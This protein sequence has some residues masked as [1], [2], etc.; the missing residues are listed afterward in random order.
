MLFHAATARLTDLLQ[1]SAWIL[2]STARLTPKHGTPLARQRL[3][4]YVQ[5][6]AVDDRGH[7]VDSGNTGWRSERGDTAERYP[8]RC[9]TS[10][11]DTARSDCQLRPPAK[12]LL[13]R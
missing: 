9:P 10:R 13:V 8:I 12:G 2:S 3:F 4:K 6:P 7:V 11:L 1:A 5:V